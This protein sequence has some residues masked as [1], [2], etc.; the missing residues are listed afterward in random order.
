[1]KTPS[2]SRFAVSRLRMLT[3]V[4]GVAILSWLSVE[5]STTLPVTILGTGASVLG[6]WLWLMTHYHGK[7]MGLWSWAVLGACMGMGAIVC[8]TGLMF[9]KTAWHSHLYPDFPTPMLLAML[10]R[11]PTWAIA[12]AML[13]VA[14]WLLRTDTDKNV[15]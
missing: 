4:W 11:V 2:A 7:G 14:V 10:A 15:L 9:F 13:G 8:A 6:I 1:M 5:D 3:I 12:G